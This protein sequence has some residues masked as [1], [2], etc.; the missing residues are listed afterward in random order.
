MLSR[1]IYRSFGAKGKA[2]VKKTATTSASGSVKGN[3]SP[4]KSNKTKEQQR[5]EEYYKMSTPL[6]LNFL[7]DTASVKVNMP[8]KGLMWFYINKNL[9]W[10]Q[11]LLNLHNE[12][13]D[14]NDEGDPITDDG[15]EINIIRLMKS[16]ESPN[17][18]NIVLKEVPIETHELIYES[19]TDPNQQCLLEI[20]NCPYHFP[21]VSKAQSYTPV[22]N[23][24]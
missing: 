17:N 23:W 21:D 6:E 12:E 16:F 15:T 20:N 14:V 4:K 11:F 7:H 10:R 22:M 3:T 2:S 18:P 19:L 8:T 24:F 5:I 13:G 9:T 1:I